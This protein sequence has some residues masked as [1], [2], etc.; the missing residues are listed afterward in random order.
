MS[1]LTLYDLSGS[2][3]IR[4]A[5]LLEELSLDYTLIHAERNADGLS[6][7]DFKVQTGTILGKVPV[8]KDGDLT[9]H[10]SGAITEYLLEKYDRDHKLDGRG[11]GIESERMKVIE[12][13][14]AAEA[15]IMVHALPYVFAQRI[16]RGVAEEL[17]EGFA[18]MVRKDLDWLEKELGRKGGGW[19]VGDSVTAADTMMGFSVMVVS[20]NRLAG[21]GVEGKWKL[22]EEWVRRIEAREAYKRAVEK[23]GFA[24]KPAEEMGFVSKK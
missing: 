9:I 5:W 6:S 8:L 13:V 2:R 18:K 15:T 17:R 10:E 22:V 20:A 24:L 21:K 1:T 7:A 12:Y 16:N 3:S 19:L 14:H 11:N 4:I 23:T